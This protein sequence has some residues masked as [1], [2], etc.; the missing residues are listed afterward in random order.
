MIDYKII[1]EKDRVCVN[2]L[3]FGTSMDTGDEYKCEG[4]RPCLNYHKD[5]TENYFVPDD[6]YLQDKY[7]CNACV[8]YCGGEPSEECGNCSRWYSDL[9][10]RGTNE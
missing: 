2:C 4:V 5:N 7:G 6:L 10:K 3:Y 8:H 1:P 9:W